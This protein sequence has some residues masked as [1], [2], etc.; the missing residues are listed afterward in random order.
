[1]ARINFKAA[2]HLR[3]RFLVYVFLITQAR[4]V[5]SLRTMRAGRGRV[6]LREKTRFLPYFSL[7]SFNGSTVIAV[8]PLKDHCLI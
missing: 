8:E 2:P 3:R 7:K 6:A 1:M 5:R 4:L